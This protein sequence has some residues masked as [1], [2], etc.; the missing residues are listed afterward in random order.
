M[1]KIK[2]RIR[3]R[4]EQVNSRRAQTPTTRISGKLLDLILLEI[5]KQLASGA[6]IRKALCQQAGISTSYLS[7]LLTEGVANRSIPSKTLKQIVTALEP[8][9]LSGFIRKSQ[10]TLFC[11]RRGSDESEV[12]RGL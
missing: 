8:Q 1:A 2:R 7:R 3:R 4:T 12:I 6:I 9:G 5:R 11:I 10:R